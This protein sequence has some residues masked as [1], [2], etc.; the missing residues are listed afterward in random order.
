[1]NFIS[2]VRNKMTD[3]RLIFLYRGN[4]TEENSIPLLQLLE[5]EMEKQHS[6]TKAERDFLC[7]FWKVCRM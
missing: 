5:K 6:V 3:E 2:Q 1:M 4:I 7:L